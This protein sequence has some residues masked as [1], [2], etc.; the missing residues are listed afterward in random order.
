MGSLLMRCTLLSLWG[1]ECWWITISFFISFG[2]FL[3][4]LVETNPTQPI[5]CSGTSVMETLKCLSD[6]E[7][8]T[9]GKE[10][11]QVL[12]TTRKF[13]P[14]ITFSL[15]I[16]LAFTLESTMIC[17]N[18]SALCCVSLLY[19]FALN[20]FKSLAYNDCY[21]I[22]YPFSAGEYPNLTL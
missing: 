5:V 20:F 16:F 19:Y 22:T 6:T 7:W 2:T 21:N 11:H 9:G 12:K 3:E 18:F 13:H 8:K 17:S 15:H 1:A 4:K 10:T 14:L